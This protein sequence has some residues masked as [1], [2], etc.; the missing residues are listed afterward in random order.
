M[1]IEFNK[2][3]SK[4]SLI[5]AIIFFIIGALLFTNPNMVIAIIS[6]LIGS[7][8]VLIGIYKFIR[9]Y[10]NTKHD[11][12]TPATDLTFGIILTLIGIIFLLLA[13]TIGV[14]VQYVCGAWML[15]SGINKLITTLQM[16]KENRSYI[17]SL[18]VSILIIVA[19]IY[20]ILKS[21]LAFNLV[22]IIMM[23][24]SVLEIIAYIG[25][26][27]ND[28]NDENTTVKKQIEENIKDAKIVEDKTDDNKK[29]KKNE[30]N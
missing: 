17:T 16:N 12:S 27:K 25:I 20:T 22:G 26:K 7:I 28:N 2:E 8:L 11:S 23:I 14:A 4:R 29:K 15:F 1:K 21:N 10:Y 18:I 19:G 5:S 9:N 24:Y 3:K 6:Y 13:D 30:K